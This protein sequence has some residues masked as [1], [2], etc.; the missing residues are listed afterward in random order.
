MASRKPLVLVSGEIQQLQ[1]GDT[2][3]GP[4]GEVDTLTLTNGDAAPH[5]LGDV[6]Y[7]SAADTGKKA[8]ADATGTK[9]AIAF[10]MGAITNGTTGA[11]QTDGIL[12]GLTGLVTGSVYYLSAATAGA[13]TV[14]APSAAGQFVVRLGI[15]IS[16]TELEI[17]IGRPITL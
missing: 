1:P 16:T 15:A 6:V 9:D 10:A 3:S 17:Q 4:F 5:A 2:L 8:K 12:S 13:M 7:I 11:Y 14:T